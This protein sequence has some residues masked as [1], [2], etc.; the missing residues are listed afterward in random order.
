MTHATKTAFLKY[1]S[2]GLIAFGLLTSLTLL[3]VLQPVMGFFLD[4]AFLSPLGSDHQLD[5]E[6]ARL[7]I[8]ISGGLLAGW[9]AT[10]YLLTTEVYA[11]D[12][13]TGGRIILVGVV[14]W[15]IVDS[16]GSVVAGAP[17]NAVL[18]VS[19]LLLFT[20]PVLWTGKA[21]ASLNSPAG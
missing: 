1:A 14:T 6:A 2:L 9:G 18:N 19:F 4:L 20:L 16:T 12:A 15:F 5:S 13:Q 7:W 3:P 8:G 17:F 11:K 10:L 21:S